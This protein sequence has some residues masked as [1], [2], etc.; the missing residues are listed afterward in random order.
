MCVVCCCVLYVIAIFLFLRFYF[1]TMK[2][3]LSSADRWKIIGLLKYS[4]FSQKQLA[5]RFHC[6]RHTIANIANLHNN[7]NNVS[8]R[9]RSGRPHKLNQ[10]KKKVLKRALRNNPNATTK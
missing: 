10:Q 2:D 6:H 5:Q 4:S 7:T 3:P 8:P 1:F 9:H